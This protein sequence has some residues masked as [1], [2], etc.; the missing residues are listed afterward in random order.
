[1]FNY[2]LNCGKRMMAVLLLSIYV[3]PLTV[4]AVHV[5]S[6]EFAEPPTVE[7][8]PELTQDTTVELVV[9]EDVEKAEEPAE[10]EPPATIDIP[11]PAAETSVQVNDGIDISES[12]IELLCKITMAEAGGEGEL[13]IR[14]VIDTVLNRVDSEYFPNTISG[15]VYQTNQFEPVATGRLNSCYVRDDIYRLVLEELANRTNNEVVFFRTTRY[16][17]CGTP[18]F[19]VGNHY[20]SKY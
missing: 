3:I 5:Y 19:V 20:F 18:L 7:S 2:V 14:L 10:P 16:H 17:S 11:A 12:D 8:T 1:M 13:G 6:T 15:V 4:G 9:I